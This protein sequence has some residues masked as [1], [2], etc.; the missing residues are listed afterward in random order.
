MTKISGHN[1]RKNK[2]KHQR[3]RNIN[4]SNACLDNI[5]YK[6]SWKQTWTENDLKKEE[7]KKIKVV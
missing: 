6:T 2:K 4:K 7:G 3:I 1:I 5:I